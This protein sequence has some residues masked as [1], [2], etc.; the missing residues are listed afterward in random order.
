[1]YL[2]CTVT[3]QVQDD[4]GAQITLIGFAANSF[5]TL[6]KGL[7]GWWVLECSHTHDLS[8]LAGI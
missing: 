8:R 5:L 2:L 4:T 3:N 7:A 1:M 6:M